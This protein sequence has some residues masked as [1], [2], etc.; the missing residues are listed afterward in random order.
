MEIGRTL[1]GI[2]DG[3]SS[4]IKRPS[5]TVKV[6]RYIEALMWKRRA[7]CER[8]TSNISDISKEGSFQAQTIIDCCD[9]RR[10]HKYNVLNLISH[11]CYPCC[12]FTSCAQFCTACFGVGFGFGVG[13]GS[14]SH[15]CGGV[16]D[17]C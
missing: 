16:S 10:S 3:G 15:S 8:C 5:G 4:T 9:V 7:L 6:S 12:T 1:M 14:K 2:M 11:D 17:V 13:V